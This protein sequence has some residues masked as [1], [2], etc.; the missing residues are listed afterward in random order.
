M[1]VYH[2]SLL[3]PRSGFSVATGKMEGLKFAFTVVSEWFILFDGGSMTPESPPAAGEGQRWQVRCGGCASNQK[4]M[5]EQIK[6]ILIRQNAI[7]WCTKTRGR[8][9]EENKGSHSPSSSL[10]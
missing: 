7:D 3:R 10:G 6:W 9:K 4:E 8:E 5:K 2:E 1:T